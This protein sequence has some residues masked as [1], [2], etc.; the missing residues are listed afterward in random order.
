MSGWRFWIDRGGTFTDVV[1]VRPDGSLATVKLLSENPGRYDD[2]AIEAI[3]RLAGSVPA[4]ADIRIGTTIATNALLER[5]GEP[6]LLVT[7]QGHG[8]ALTIGYQDRPDIFARRVRRAPPLAAEVLE[9][10]ERVA[11]DGTVLR[12]LDVAAAEA[13]LRAAY[14]RGLRAVAIVLMHGWRFTAHE[15][16]LAEVARAIGFAQVSASHAV[17]PIQKLVAR[18]DTTLADAYLSPALDRYTAGLAAAL[19]EPLFMQSSGGLAARDAFRG[20][21]ALL[22]G[23]AGGIVGMAQTARASGFDHVIGFDMGGTSTDV[24]LYAGQYDRRT[25]AVIAGT[26]VAVPMM[27]IDTVAAGG[28]SICGWDAGRFVVGPQSAGAVPGPACYRRGGPLTVT[29]CNLVLGRIQPDHF[30]A[31]FGPEGDQPLDRAAAEE[32]LDALIAGSGTG[33]SREAAAAGLVD[34]AVAEMASAIRAISVARGHDPAAYA[35]ATFG[36]AGGQHA[37]L[38]A[39]AL[40]IETVMVHPLAGVLSAYGMGLA[41][42]RALREATLDVALDDAAALDAA[43]AELAAA[44]QADLMAQGVTTDAIEAS[45]RLR[46]A[47]TDQGIEVPYGTPE[48]MRAAFEAAHRRQYGFL[49]QDALV[50]DLIRVEAVAR[51]AA[52]LPPPALP[53]ESEAPE[54]GRAHV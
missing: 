53:T 23:P 38:V 22:S 43:H 10:D 52:A 5:K 11:A 15:A 36:G 44:A 37:C 2:A 41:D 30:P 33:L 47:R 32:R 26:R 19:G 49:G 29:D 9:V 28:G 7:T 1:A 34:I 31:V 45:V 13:G 51:S 14:D 42:R 35:L 16:R 6:V 4:D 27:R 17:A 54:I 3:R 50:A 39:D 25:D 24:S 18:G 40:G 48:A 20:K 21:D 46:Y 12:P 8:D